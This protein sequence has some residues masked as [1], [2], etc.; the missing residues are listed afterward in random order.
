MINKVGGVSNV[1]NNYIISGNE[2]YVLRVDE[3]S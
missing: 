2:M 3:Q 1:V